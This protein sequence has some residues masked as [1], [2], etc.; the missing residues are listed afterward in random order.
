[1]LPS[2]DNNQRSFDY[3]IIMG[4]KDRTTEVSVEKKCHT[5]FYQTLVLS[6]LNSKI[7]KK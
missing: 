6:I 5:F 4:R 3:F 2:Y 1:M 7:I